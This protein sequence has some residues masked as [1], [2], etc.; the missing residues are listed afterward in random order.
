MKKLTFL[1]LT[2]FITS[3]LLISCTKKVE[4]NPSNVKPNSV[5]TVVTSNNSNNVESSI[6]TEK[7]ALEK[8]KKVT[9]SLAE[10]YKLEF[11]RLETRGQK[12]YFVIHFFE[13]VIDNPETGESHQATVT[14]YYVNK[15]TGEVYEW[16]LIEDK[17]KEVAEAES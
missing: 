5:N 2:A 7:D 9:G 8:V 3:S 16:D 4:V 11:D 17:L 12:E 13:T 15:L 1:I 6:L 10:G 14:W